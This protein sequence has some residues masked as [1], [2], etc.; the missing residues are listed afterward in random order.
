MGLTKKRELFVYHYVGECYYNATAA[1]RKA[2][3]KHP[4]EEGSRLLAIASVKAAIKELMEENGLS[5]ERV[6]ADI[7]KLALSSDISH[8]LSWGK[9]GDVKL[10]LQAAYEAGHMDAVKKIK[11]DEQ[12]R[13]TDIE[14]HDKTALLRDLGR[15]HGM[16]KSVSKIDDGDGVLKIILVD[17]SQKKHD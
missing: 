15:A 12:G 3:Y 5:R 10:D 14:L 17:E 4:K 13:V 16:F 2:G 9:D 8:F 11:V 1:A 7:A 6:A